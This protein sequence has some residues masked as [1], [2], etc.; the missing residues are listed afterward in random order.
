MDQSITLGSLKDSSPTVQIL[1]KNI[2]IG[3]AE[4][5]R[6]KQMSHHPVNGRLGDPFDLSVRG[7][8]ILLTHTLYSVDMGSTWPVH[9]PST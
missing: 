6:R 8:P 9:S 5:H 2:G 4:S 7:V 3:H 1:S